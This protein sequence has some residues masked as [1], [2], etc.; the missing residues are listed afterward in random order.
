MTCQHAQEREVG[1]PT[2]D[3]GVTLSRLRCARCGRQ[4]SR[5]DFRPDPP[6]AEHC[7]QRRRR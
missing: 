6:R 1:R 7:V 2:K 3:A 4:W 5:V